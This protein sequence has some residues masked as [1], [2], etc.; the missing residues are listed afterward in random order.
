MV[1]GRVFCVGEVVLDVVFRGWECVGMPGG[2]MLNTAVSLGR[3]GRETFMVGDLCRDLAGDFIIGFLENNGVSIR[4]LHRY[5]EGKTPLALAFLDEEQKAHYSFYRNFPEDRFPKEMPEIN[6][7]DIILFGS[8]YAITKGFHTRLVRWIQAA[9]QQGAL[10]I[11]DPNFRKPH[12]PELELLKPMIMENI[13]LAD[14][15]KG[16]D[17]DFSLIFETK[18]F[19]ST[20]PIILEAGCRNLVYTRGASG[21]QARFGGYHLSLPAHRI[22]PV[23]TIGAGDAFSAGLI[24]GILEYGF[25][26]TPDMLGKALGRGVEWAGEVCGREENYV[27]RNEY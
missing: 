8:F 21:V 10:I 22:E 18:D 13:G 23:S 3:R 2:S 6:K 1:K 26:F 11:Y 25:N 7:G 24:D 16:S 19:S 9:K 12:L 5:D 20:W 17:E 4:W 14:I 15:V 27:G